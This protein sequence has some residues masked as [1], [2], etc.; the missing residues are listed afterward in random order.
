MG[1]SESDGERRIEHVLKAGQSVLVQVTKDPLKG[2]GARLTAQISL[3]GRYLVYVPD[4]G[5]SGISRRL[6]DRERERLRRVIKDIRPSEGGVIIR[7]AAEGASEEELAADLTPLANET[8][9]VNAPGV[10]LES[11]LADMLI[12]GGLDFA[13]VNIDYMPFPDQIPALATGALV[14]FAG[15]RAAFFVP[16]IVCICVGIGFLALVWNTILGFLFFTQRPDIWTFVGAAIIFGSVSRK[17]CC[18]R[19]PSKF[20][21]RVM[22]NS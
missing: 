17:R 6:S 14:D 1:T 7:T 12:R 20:V 15:W 21:E 22:S 4:G 13:E 8:F 2:K 5:A 9:G 10:V 19:Q 18:G 3:P 11:M 16:G